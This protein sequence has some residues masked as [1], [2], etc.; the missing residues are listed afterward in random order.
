MEHV[1]AA[2]KIISS[3]EPKDKT[4]CNFAIRGGGYNPQVGSANINQGV[5]IDL[6]SMSEIE[7]SPDETI[8]SAGS[9]SL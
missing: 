9:G 1:S 4:E 5:T 3:I 8:T 6:S 7:V 2:V